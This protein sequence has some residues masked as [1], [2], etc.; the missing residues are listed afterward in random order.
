MVAL[1]CVLAL[2]SADSATVGASALHLRR[3]LHISNTD[4][5]LLVT[6]TPWSRRSASLP[7]G[8]MADRFR[9]T[10]TLGLTVL[11]WGVAMV[12]SATV[13][14]F[15][16]LLLARLALGL[17]TAAAGPIVASLVG[18]YFQAPNGAASTATSSPASCRGP[19]WAS[20]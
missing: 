14:S 17:V 11:A 2:A 5:G 4:I 9:R 10:R 7:F 3:S 12:W 8:V 13:S 15:D 1:A 20:P 16:K 18:D 6:V 19:A